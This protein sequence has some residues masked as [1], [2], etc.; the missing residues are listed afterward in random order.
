MQIAWFN[1]QQPLLAIFV[2]DGAGSVSQVAKARCSPSM[3]RWL[4]CRK[5]CRAGN[6][7]G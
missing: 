1:D 4:R 5:K 7:G 6:W 2:A 3:K